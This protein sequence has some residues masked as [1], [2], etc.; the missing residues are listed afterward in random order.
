MKH[1]LSHDVTAYSLRLIRCVAA[2]HTWN[3]KCAAE[4]HKVD[5]KP[6]E[7]QDGTLP[8]NRTRLLKAECELLPRNAHGQA[9]ANGAKNWVGAHASPAAGRNFESNL[10]ATFCRLRHPR[11]PS[12]ERVHLTR[13]FTLVPINHLLYFLAYQ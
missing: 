1:E 5:G 13:S 7:N 12:E 4:K 8:C 11:W 10:A 2:G 9:H 6:S 3:G